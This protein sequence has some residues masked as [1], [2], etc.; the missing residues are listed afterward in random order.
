MC[1]LAFEINSNEEDGEDIS[2]SDFRSALIKRM[3]NLDTVE[4][5]R[6]AILPPEDTVENFPRTNEAYKENFDE[7]PYCESDQV[8]YGSLDFE[9]DSIYQA[10]LCNDCGKSWSASYAICGYVKHE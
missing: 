9:G 2:L 5:L 10:C 7:C 4:E 8:H 3:H 6:E 1:T